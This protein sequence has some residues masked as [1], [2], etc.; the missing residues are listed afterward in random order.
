MTIFS[1]TKWFFGRFAVAAVLIRCCYQKTMV[2]SRMLGKVITDDFLFIHFVMSFIL[3]LF[4]CRRHYVGR[5]VSCFFSVPFC[6]SKR[7]YESYN[8]Y[9]FFH[10]QMTVSTLIWL[11]GSGDE[12]KDIGLAIT[13]WMVTS[14]ETLADYHT[15]V[16]TIETLGGYHTLNGEDQ[17]RH[18]LAITHWLETPAGYHTV[19]DEDQNRHRLVITHWMTKTKRDTS[20]LS[21]T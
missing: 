15:M 6:L 9:I 12:Y 13:H 7:Y 20:L 2:Q 1:M 16:M 18:Q 3:W 21:H 14:K 19:N 17:K 10:R 5:F 4:R 11:S 8:K